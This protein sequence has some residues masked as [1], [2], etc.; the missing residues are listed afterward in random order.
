[1]ASG[2]PR[3]STA[4]V[5]GTATRHE[6]SST[7]TYKP[8]FV[9]YTRL[10]PANV[11]DCAPLWG[12]AETYAPGVLPRVLAAAARLL[13]QERA[14]GAI[15]FE[16]GIPRAFNLTVFAADAF[17]EAYLRDPHPQI[18]KRLLLEADH[19]SFS[20][21][22]SRRD[23]AERNAGEGLQVVVANCAVDPR[24]RDG[25]TVYGLSIRSFFFVHHGYRVARIT[26]EVFGP[27]VGW[28]ETSGSYE[29]RAT[30][31]LRT[32][33]GPLPSRVATVTREQA[34]AWGNPILAA[35]AYTPPRL[36]FTPS[37]QRLL[38]EALSGV[39]DLTLS[40]RLGIP[41]S[42][43]KARWSRLQM[44][45][46]QLAPELFHDLPLAIGSNRGSQTRHVILQ[47]VR[48]HPAELT[49]YLWS[50]ARTGAAV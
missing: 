8:S 2:I 45:T 49:P 31:D 35:F 34:A 48:D 9:D 40:A 50:A 41:I 7:G 19:P 14:T 26:T 20:G 39:T 13:D 47:Y 44:R 46:R 33:R 16:N 15:V 43:V 11:T 18:G 21:V 30:F 4:R 42:A 23:I 29:I 6:D 5:H 17:V 32:P 25:A 22:L 36:R 37:E 27:S 24:T 12:G 3:P 28:V 1:M 10:T 38:A